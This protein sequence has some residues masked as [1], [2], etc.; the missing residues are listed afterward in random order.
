M[1]ALLVATPLLF[2]DGPDHGAYLGQDYVFGPPGGWYSVGHAPPHLVENLHDT[3]LFVSYG[4]GVPCAADDPGLDFDGLGPD[5][6][7]T[8]NPPI[9]TALF[10][11]LLSS[12]EV[13]ASQNSQTFDAAALAAGEH[14]DIDAMSCGTHWWSTWHR[15]FRTALAWN[16]FGATPSTVSTFTY[17]TATQS[18]NAW[19]F[20]Y[21]LA[22][23]PT[24]LTTL[25]RQGNEF[26][27]SG[28]G[29]LTVTTPSYCTITGDLPFTTTLPTAPCRRLRLQALV[30][31]LARTFARVRV[32]VTSGGQ[33]V[34]HAT[35]RAGNARDTTNASGNASFV[36]QRTLHARRTIVEA[37]CANYAHV[38]R[39][40]RIAGRR[41]RASLTSPHNRTH[42]GAHS[43]FNARLSADRLT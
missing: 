15:A 4:T 43:G 3:R 42:A 14:V 21:D 33:P 10:P 23:P 37:A 13:T 34:D 2:A 19:G 17:T 25:V 29:R 7:A 39:R 8:L 5:A 1:Q 9:G 11:A 32:T 20:N 35:V 24:A 28:S 12:L 16:F 31:K 26:T 36:I 18:G 27:A 6:L 40:I 30:T 38:R 22:S 41:R